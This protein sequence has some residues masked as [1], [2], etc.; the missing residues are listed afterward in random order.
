VA[1][2]KLTIFRFFKPCNTLPK[3]DVHGEHCPKNTGNG[4]AS[5]GDSD[6]GLLSESSIVSKKN[7]KHKL[8]TKKELKFLHWTALTSRFIPTAQVCRKKGPQ[9][10][11][12]SRGGLTTKIH[13]I[14]ANPDWSEKD[15]IIQSVPGMGDEEQSGVDR[16]LVRVG[17]AQ[18]PRGC[19]VGGGGTALS[20]QR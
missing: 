8:L 1:V 2:L 18:S 5:I 10:I 7:S 4:P 9:S 11:G 14:V 20:G 19:G 16:G 17:N 13:S 6:T 15:K 3:T 12:K